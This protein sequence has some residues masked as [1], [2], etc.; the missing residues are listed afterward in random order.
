MHIRWRKNA[1]MKTLYWICRSDLVKAGYPI[2]TAVL[3]RGRLDESPSDDQ[4]QAARARGAQLSHEAVDWVWRPSGPRGIRLKRNGGFIYFVK[5][6][7]AIKIGFAKDVAR[8]VK[9]MQ[10]GCPEPLEIIASMQGS[11]ATEKQLHRKFEDLC[12]RGEWFRPGDLLL[13]FIAKVQNGGCWP[14]STPGGLV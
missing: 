2:K 7:E 5:M 11:P 8:R 12:I 6:G 1:T 10:G 14:V 13:N 3:W 4:M 9:H